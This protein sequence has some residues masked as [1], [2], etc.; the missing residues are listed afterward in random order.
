M[1]DYSSLTTGVDGLEA[2]VN[3]LLADGG[4]IYQPLTESFSGNLAEALTGISGSTVSEK[5]LSRTEMLAQLANDLGLG[6]VSHLTTG[7]ADLLA[8]IA[9]SDGISA[10]FEWPD[11]TNTG[12]SGSLTVTEGNFVVTSDGQ[13]VENRNF[14]TGAVDINGKNNVT[15]RNC[16]FGGAVLYAVDNGTNPGTGLTV[17]RCTFAGM[18]IAIRGM[19][20][21]TYNNISAVENGILVPAGSVPTVITNNYLH[22]FSFAGDPHYDGIE[23]NGGNNNV[24]VY[25]NT[26][27]IGQSQTSAV[28]ICNIDGGS[29]N[30]NVE[31]NKL[32]GGTFPIYVD[33]HFTATQLT[34]VVVKNNLLAPG[35]VGSVNANAS[36]PS[37]EGNYDPATGLFFA[38]QS[39][40]TY[41]G[42]AVFTPSASLGSTDTNT[43]ISFRTVATLAADVSGSFRFVWT[44]QASRDVHATHFAAG[45]SNGTASQTTAVPVVVTFGGSSTPPVIENGEY[46]ISDPIDLGPMV[47]GDKIVIVTDIDSTAGQGQALGTGNTNVTTYFKSAAQ[48]YNE[49]NPASMTVSANNNFGLMAIVV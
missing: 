32:T 17:T 15:I 45:K 29:D 26:I 46:L 25:R 33:A 44:A 3:Q 48:T 19:G 21:F 4:Y 36:T 14:T 24:T 7:Y 39:P 40:K 30:I 28:M 49:A 2:V 23:M 13:V 11:A 35:A 1:T 22:D 37:I 6:P 31:E 5:V 34:N 9:S 42:T 12:S 8:L 47:T 20:T 10:V 38:G 18:F 27:L 43:N 41:P 16:Q